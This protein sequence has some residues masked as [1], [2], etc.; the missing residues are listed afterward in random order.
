MKNHILTSILFIGNSFTARNDMAGMVKSFA[1]DSLVI[2]TCTRGAAS[3]QSHSKE[4]SFEN[5]VEGRD[6]DN[7]VLQEQSI[8]LLLPQREAA[9]IQHVESLAE[10]IRTYNNNTSLYLFE[11]WAYKY[12]WGYFYPTKE[13]MQ[14]KLFEGY[15]LVADRIDARPVLVGEA[16]SAVE[17]A[18]INWYDSDG[19][20]PSKE[21]SFLAAVMF[22]RTIVDR[23]RTEFPCPKGI[24][25][26]T[27]RF[28][29][30]VSGTFISIA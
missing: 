1:P 28:I 11:T 20:H 24:K 3:W 18:A 22:Y 12:G 9:S 13:A 21:A 29:Q 10:L 6:W 5:C 25:R 4:R 27:C 26:E 14:A 8:M 2:S 17:D 16:V 7:V 23:D 15:M 30:N 19:Q